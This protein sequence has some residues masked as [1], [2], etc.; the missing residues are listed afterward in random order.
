MSPRGTRPCHKLAPL[1]SQWWWQN[2][3]SLQ[4]VRV[5]QST[6]G[7]ARP[8]T[9]CRGG[10]WPHASDFA[11]KVSP[12]PAHCHP[13]SQFAQAPVIIR[14]ANLALL[15]GRW[16]LFSFL[17][18]KKQDDFWGKQ[19]LSTLLPGCSLERGV[20]H[21]SFC[22]PS[23]PPPPKERREKEKSVYVPWDLPRSWR[24]RSGRRRW[25]CWRPW[26]GRSRR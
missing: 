2:Q 11:T 19:G 23:P 12:L 10:S 18:N 1:G 8:P 20:L 15:L 17:K 3:L 7:C 21:C 14:G 22:F 4:Q 13:A 16:W 9:K 5:P 6:R 26:C 25:R 24:R